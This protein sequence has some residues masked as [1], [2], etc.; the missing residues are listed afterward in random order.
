MPTPNLTEI[1]PF[2][3]TVSVP[4]YT[5]RYPTIILVVTYPEQSPLRCDAVILKTEALWSFET[6]R[7]T[8]QTTQRHIREDFTLQY[9][10]TQNIYHTMW[11]YIWLYSK[12]ATAIKDLQVTQCSG[13][14]VMIH[15]TTG[16]Q[17]YK[18]QCPTMTH[19]NTVDFML[20]LFIPEK[21]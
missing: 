8:H 21:P 4:N 13:I 2:P 18:Q 5:V 6:S 20:K 11:L 7:T 1:L 10:C 14:K 3:P 17:C 15:K 19:Q 16:M 9:H 12:S